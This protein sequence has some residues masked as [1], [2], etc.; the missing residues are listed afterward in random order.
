MTK[1][2]FTAVFQ[3]IFTVFALA[4]ITPNPN[5]G[6]STRVSS[7]PESVFK[8]FRDAG[9]NPTNH[10]LTGEERLKVE[11]AF[12][13]L[14]P[15]H[16]QVLDAWLHNISFMDNM[17]NTALTSRLEGGDSAKFN[18]T[19]RAGMLNETISEW[20]TKKE[21]TIYYDSIDT[22]HQVSIDA[23]Q[24]DAIVYVLLHEATHVVD[25]VLNITPH[26][27]QRD[28]LV[29]PTSYTKNIWFK[30]NVPDNRF[31]DSV[32]E[33]TLFRNGTK[34]SK[35]LAPE[36][37]QQLGETPFASL[38]SLASWFEDLAEMET[39]Y[40]LTTKLN[41]PFRIVVKLNNKEI[42][43]YEPMKNNLIRR[44]LTNLRRFYN[45]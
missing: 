4:Q 32:L 44:R 18:I 33:K 35:A 27:D 26:P 43:S 31:I 20:A 7:A 42:V 38:Y 12:R 30:M 11:K 21:N 29:S 1:L 3:L 34:V 25:A 28:A 24:M 22:G 19:F 16:K 15:L 23:G 36:I 40:H 10:E 6:L 13:L 9:M 45:V 2:L 37:Y 14:P 8:S 41:Q 17:P 39:I 5:S